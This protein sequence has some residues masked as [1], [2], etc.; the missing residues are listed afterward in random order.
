MLHPARLDKG[1]VMG[2]NY[3]AVFCDGGGRDEICVAG[4]KTAGNEVS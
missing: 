4:A 1:R 2:Y 3:T